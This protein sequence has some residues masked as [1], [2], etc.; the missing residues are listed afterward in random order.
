MKFSSRHRFC[1]LAVLVSLSCG[2]LAAQ[3]VSSQTQ[4]ANP[5][6]IQLQQPQKQQWEIGFVVKSPG[7][8]TGV[9]GTMTVPMPWPEQKVTIIKEDLSA[10][11][12]LRPRIVMGDVKQLLVTIPRVDAGATVKAIVT[13]EVERSLIE[14][15]KQTDKLYIP[16]LITPDLRKYM[17]VSPY[18]ETTNAKII[19]VSRGLGDDAENAWQKV[20][21]IF[22]WVRDHVKYKFDEELRGALTALEQGEGDCEE[23]TSLFIAICRNNGIPARSVWIPGHCYPE[24]YLEDVNGKGH[25]FPCQIAGSRSFGSMPEY[26]PVLQKGDNFRVPGNSRPQRY[27]AETFKASRSTQPPM[28]QFI[29]RQAGMDDPFAPVLK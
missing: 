1:I 20:E 12:K 16:K 25:W 8:M 28:V 22:D 5:Y 23:L 9:T 24:F 7:L 3:T 26:R 13:V 14:K 19:S 2:S 6:A 15:P 29:R 21:I 17:G 11:V 4:K 18:I 27:V 10:G